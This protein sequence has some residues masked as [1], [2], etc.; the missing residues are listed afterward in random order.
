MYYRIIS[1][2]IGPYIEFSFVA[3]KH[4]TLYQCCSTKKMKC[5][6][7]LIS[8][9]KRDIESEKKGDRTIVACAIRL[10]PCLWKTF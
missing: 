3:A 2:Y 6:G 5:T 1:W 8:V 7:N 9:Q 10:G 4:E